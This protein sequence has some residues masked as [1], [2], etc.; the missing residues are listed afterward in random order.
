[1]LLCASDVIFY[2]AMI[3][4]VAFF[5][6]VMVMMV[7]L[8]CFNQGLSYSCRSHLWVLPPKLVFLCKRPAASS[9]LFPYCFI[10]LPYFACPR[11]AWFPL[12]GL[13]SLLPW[14]SC[15]FVMLVHIT[16]SLILSV[17]VV[18]ICI[19]KILFHGYCLLF[20]HNVLYSTSYLTACHLLTDG[21]N[22]V[23]QF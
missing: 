19:L 8:W 6:V 10:C 4:L 18:L 11:S 14:Y 1:V 13:G 17:V 9:A 23:G 21:E 5:F 2:N 16:V 7:I 15:S 22:L 12:S 3:T 20:L